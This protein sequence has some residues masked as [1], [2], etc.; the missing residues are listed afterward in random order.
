M[1]GYYTVHFTGYGCDSNGASSGNS[2]GYGSG[3]V[4]DEMLHELIVVIL[5]VRATMLLVSRRQ[6]LTSASNCN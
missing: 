4:V 2:C 6:P 3:A 5:I 1:G